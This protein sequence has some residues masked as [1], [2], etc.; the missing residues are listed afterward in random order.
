MSTC[1]FYRVAAAGPV[2]FAPLGMDT[3]R[4]SRTTGESGPIYSIFTMGSAGEK[5]SFIEMLG[6]GKRARG[7]HAYEYGTHYGHLYRP[8]L[9]ELGHVRD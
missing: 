8:S 5:K 4:I 7:K 2:A 9:G 1:F 6:R 3:P